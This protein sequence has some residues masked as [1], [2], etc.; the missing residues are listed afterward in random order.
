MALVKLS[1]KDFD[2]FNTCPTD[3]L[4]DE[5]YRASIRLRLADA[6]VTPEESTRYQ[7]D[8]DRLTAL[9]NISL[10]RKGKLNRE[11]FDLKVE[12]ITP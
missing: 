12:I 9:R 6:P 7:A 3:K 1:Q 4:D 10:L 5:I 2:N 8:V 11:G